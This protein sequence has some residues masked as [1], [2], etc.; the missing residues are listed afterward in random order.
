MTNNV[1]KSN[2]TATPRDQNTE[3]STQPS[4]PEEESIEIR[5]ADPEQP[6]DIV[7]P[8][9]DDEEE[10]EEQNSVWVGKGL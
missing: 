2:A 10:D 7:H 9:I 8:S 4:V 1:D 3:S 6:L 5:F